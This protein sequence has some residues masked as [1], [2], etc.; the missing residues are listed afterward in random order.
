MAD[1]IRK[2]L[3]DVAGPDTL[4]GVADDAHLFEAGLV[5]SLHLIELVTAIEEH[6]GITVEAVDLVP[7]NFQSIEAMAA[8]AARK[9]GV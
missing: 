5:D 2:L 8:F 7:E 3:S 1:T 9:R 4:V 6:F